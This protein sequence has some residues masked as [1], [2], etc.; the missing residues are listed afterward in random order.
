MDLKPPIDRGAEL[1]QSGDAARQA[2]GDVPMP[3]AENEPPCLF[4]PGAGITAA[5]VAEITLM[6]LL[7]MSGSPYNPPPGG[8]RDIA[9]RAERVAQLSPSARQFL[10]PVA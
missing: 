10:K 8:L 2:P 6:F 5:D 7:D 9:L 3:T 4:R 1:V